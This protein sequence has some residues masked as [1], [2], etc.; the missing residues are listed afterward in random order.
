L[1][2]PSLLGCFEGVHK[3][4]ASKG[5]ILNFRLKNKLSSLGFRN[6]L[7]MEE[8]GVL[9]GNLVE[10][11]HKH[12]SKTSWHLGSIRNQP[13]NLNSKILKNFTKSARFWRVSGL[14]T[15]SFGARLQNMI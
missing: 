15:K 4:S 2:T 11:N 13:E 5:Q 14:G 8:M 6:F 9:M 10:T 3:N 1:H 7:E 12:V